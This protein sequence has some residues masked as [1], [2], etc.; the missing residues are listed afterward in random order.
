MM[1]PFGDADQGHRPQLRGCAD[2]DAT[3]SK[4]A[5]RF[6]ATD[7][8]IAALRRLAAPTPGY[9]VRVTGASMR[10][11][12]RYGTLSALL[13]VTNPLVAQAPKP[14]PEVRKLEVWVGTWTYE[15][16]AKA[17]PIG[18]AA[19]VSGTQTGRMTL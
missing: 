13:F 3:A 18:P 6:S 15:G 19:K 14:S 11:V 8:M 1:E 2:C 12:L 16:D 9:L 5:P 7:V 10:T 4:L 17:T